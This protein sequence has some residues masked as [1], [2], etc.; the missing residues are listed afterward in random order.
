MLELYDLEKLVTFRNEGTLVAAS[1]KLLI[2]Q[3]ALSRSM[4]KLEDEIGVELFTRSKNRMELN[5]NGILAAELAEKLL[6]EADSLV[7]RVRQLD[8]SRHT[9]SVGSCA[10]EPLWE[11]VATLGSAYPGMTISSEMAEP[12]AL[13]SGVQDGTYS[14]VILTSPPELNGVEVIPF[15]GEKLCFLL[16]MN[17]PLAGER[18]L[19]LADLNGETMLLRPNLGFWTKTLE[20]LPDTHFLVQQEDY[21]FGELLRASSLPA[22][23]TDRVQWR[24]GATEGRIAIP[25][26]DPG[27]SVDYLVAYRSTEKKHLTAA[28]KLIAAY[29]H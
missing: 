25:I 19:H 14:L 20:S 6:G 22:F 15:G 12:E 23:T 10:P 27:T 16:P 3:P 5:E 8:R 2:S 18:E 1:E 26:T 28:L 24:Y 11:L 29:T 7:A 13:I 17:H 4:R 9:L 21:A